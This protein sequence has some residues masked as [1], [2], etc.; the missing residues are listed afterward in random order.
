VK[1]FLD[2][3]HLSDITLTDLGMAR[4]NADWEAH[5]RALAAKRG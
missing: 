2:T 5:Q 4:F 3:A 1:L